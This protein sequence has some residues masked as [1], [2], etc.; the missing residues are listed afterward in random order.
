VKIEDIL[1]HVEIGTKSIVWM[2]LKMQQLSR[3]LIFLMPKK[4]AQYSLVN[5][6]QTK[7]FWQYI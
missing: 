6:M 4:T 7:Y 5:F 1:I 2:V 3:S